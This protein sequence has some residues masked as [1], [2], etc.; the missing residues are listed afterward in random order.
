MRVSDR[1]PSSEGSNTEGQAAMTDEERPGGTGVAYFDMRAELRRIAST[2]VVDLDGTLMTPPRPILDA[3]GD[4]RTDGEPEP[5]AV[6]AMRAMHAAGWRLVVS[7]SRTWDRWGS[8][9]LAWA[10]AIKVWLDVHGMP[11]DEVFVGSGKPA[12]AAY[13]DD[14]AIRYERNWPEI[15]ERLGEPGERSGGL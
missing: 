9:R 5:G 1:D 15:A 14:N 13:I 3:S 12:A 11:Y 10:D 4:L 6:E 8:Q 7:S 2:V